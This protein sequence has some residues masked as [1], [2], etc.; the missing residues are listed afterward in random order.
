MFT[1]GSKQVIPFFTTQLANRQ[2]KTHH[3]FPNLLLLC[4]I[5]ISYLLFLYVPCVSLFIF[6]L[7]QLSRR[8]TKESCIESLAFPVNN[9]LNLNWDVIPGCFPYVHQ[10]L[11]FLA[12][13]FS[14]ADLSSKVAAVN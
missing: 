11:A 10:M 7:D 1:V 8:S 9:D 5:I 4:K 6:F 13:L 14:R 12:K 3:C 2:I